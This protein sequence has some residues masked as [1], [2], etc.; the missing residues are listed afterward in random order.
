MLAEIWTWIFVAMALAGSFYNATL[1]VKL[2]YVLWLISNVYLCAYNASIG[3]YSQ[4]FM[5]GAYLV[6]TFIGIKNTYKDK[7]WFRP[8][9]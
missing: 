6:T 7:Y 3:Q 1:R 9:K 5:F 8:N 2:S 4:A